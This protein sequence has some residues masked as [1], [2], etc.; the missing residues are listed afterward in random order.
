MRVLLLP[1]SHQRG[2]GLLANREVQLEGEGLEQWLHYMRAGMVKLTSDG[3]HR[4]K[5][6]A[7]KA[8]PIA[9]TVTTRGTLHLER[10]V[11]WIG[12]CK[13]AIWETYRRL[14]G[15]QDTRGTVKG[16]LP[17]EEWCD[18]FEDSIGRH[19]EAVR[20]VFCSFLLF[21]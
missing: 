12:E 21:L 13:E 15:G 14:E 17:Q 7:V 19:G 2:P 8:R 3:D 5:P 1:R 10:A 4:A 20:V 11:R 18:E 9:A 6:A 16:E